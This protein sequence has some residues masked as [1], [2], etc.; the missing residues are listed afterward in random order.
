MPGI[1]A[2]ADFVGDHKAAVAP[3][4]QIPGVIES[5]RCPGRITVP[6]DAAVR[7]ELVDLALEGQS[8]RGPS[9]N[10]ARGKP[11]GAV[12]NPDILR[13]R[14]PL[15]PL[16]RFN[17]VLPNALARRVDL[18]CIVREEV[19]GRWVEPV[20]PVNRRCTICEIFLHSLGVLP[21]RAS[22]IWAPLLS[23]RRGSCREHCQ[24]AGAQQHSQ[25]HFSGLHFI[26]PFA[27]SFEIA[28]LLPISS[29][30][31]PNIAP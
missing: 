24:C 7:D 8:K 16:R 1:A 10:A 4:L 23:P 12:E 3:C 29:P 13:I 15:R 2:F 22:A 26:S 9:E 21:F 20:W 25:G 28:S 18:K 19:C 31:A 30:D 14:I 11:G 17:D 5:R 27:T 6:T